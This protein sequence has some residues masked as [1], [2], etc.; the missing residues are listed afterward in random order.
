MPTS[1]AVRGA[2]GRPLETAAPFDLP[3]MWYGGF[4]S[5]YLNY[6]FQLWSTLLGGFLAIVGGIATTIYVQLVAPA[7]ER[8]TQ[9]RQAA[10]EL[11]SILAE[12][13]R[14]NDEEWEN[15]KDHL[16]FRLYAQAL[17]I[18]SPEIREELIFISNALDSHGALQAF[19]NI[20]ERWA[21]AEL[22]VAGLNVLGAYLRGEHQLPPETNLT[23]R[24]RSALKEARATIEEEDSMRDGKNSP[25][26]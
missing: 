1:E 21:R 6:M 19:G 2:C 12:I 4:E 8:R 25:E 24:A 5:V 22:P 7:A 14:V 10:N 9:S 3:R 17:L 15:R 16:L 13:R 26:N 11:L 23:S 20:S 18:S